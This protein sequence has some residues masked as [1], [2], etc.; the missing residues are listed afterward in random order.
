M[1]SH[2]VL[3]FS[4]LL[5]A[6]VEEVPET[7]FSG[8]TSMITFLASYKTETKT[9]ISDNGKV[10]WCAGDLVSYS[11]GRRSYSPYNS[12][13]SIE[14]DCDVASLS[15][16]VNNNASWLVALYTGQNVSVSV[17]DEGEQV[18]FIPETQTGLFKDAHISVARTNSLQEGSVL[19]F[20][21]VTSLIKFTLD[22]NDVGY[23]VFR[24]NRFEEICGCTYI[25]LRDEGPESAFNEGESRIRIDIHGSGDYYISTLPQMFSNGFTIECYDTEGYYLGTATSNKPL[26]LA[27]S[28]VKNIGIIDNRLTK[29]YTDLSRDETANCYL[30][31]T[32]GDYKFNCMVQGNSSDAISGDPVTAEVLWESVGSETAPAIGDV[33]ND[34]KLQDGFVCFSARKDGNASIAIRDSDGVILWSWHIWVCRGYIP[35]YT[36]Q[37]YPND[38]GIMMDRNLGATS[39][40]PGDSKSYGLLYQWGRKDPFLPE[41]NYNYSFKIKS[42]P[43]EWKNKTSDSSIGTIAFAIS[44]PTV[45]IQANSV[46]HDWLYTERNTNDASRWNSAKTKYDPCPPGYRVPDGGVYGI[47]AE[48]FG[49]YSKQPNCSLTW[50][51]SNKGIDFSS[52]LGNGVWYPA[53][54]LN[55]VG[56]GTYLS[57][58]NNWSTT[59]DFVFS[60]SGY[61]SSF[62][63]NSSYGYRSSVRCQKIEAVTDLS[64]AGNANCYLV[65]KKG[66]YKINAVKGNSN[67]SVGEVSS[68]DLLWDDYIE[69]EGLDN[70][71]NIGIVSNFGYRDGYIFFQTFGKA[72]NAVIAA[73]DSEGS[74]LWS[75]HIWCVSSMPA[76]QYY[77]N[78]AGAMMDR[79]LGATSAKIGDIQSLGLLYQ[80]GRKDPF[81]N[82]VYRDSGLAAGLQYLFSSV[83]SD[84]DTGTIE[85]AVA[86]PMTF[87][88]NRNDWLYSS[89]GTS[90]R[91]SEEKTIY[92]PCPSGYRV[93]T[94]GKEGIWS[95]SA[96]SVSNIA[97]VND[98]SFDK[99]NYG[100]NFTKFYPYGGAWYP[101]VGYKDYKTGELVDVG[102]YAI[103]GSTSTDVLQFNTMYNFT[104]GKTV[105]NAYGRAIRCQRE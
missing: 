54:F 42:N 104:Y 58:L 41:Q 82:S 65:D 98:P 103:Y 87:I 105:A 37:K 31:S 10:S 53:T 16:N 64:S 14:E 97:D 3:I 69:K 91:W 84:G 50:D 45:F 66:R 12:T 85:Y 76:D 56:A 28:E 68:V 61:A 74:I 72:G 81:I 27:R 46:N 9:A 75:W 102:S 20:R 90:P 5:T 71:G 55:G 11:S 1:K 17:I 100:M 24:G 96:G 47:W 6:C 51:A 22:R 38:A 15:L 52:V 40:E 79:N 36:D 35:S 93:P 48:A 23:V 44:N 99:Q 80:W 88:T 33:I 94:G 29:S 101:A 92:D 30:I 7:I 86:H 39:K 57:C 34:V 43:S 2:I 73:K 8:E 18:V 89:S 78:N 25:Y 63:Q 21:N 70:A 95:V 49:G 4:L 77:A 19:T 59:F 32:P 67:E 26:N 60:E 62:V 83:D 13:C